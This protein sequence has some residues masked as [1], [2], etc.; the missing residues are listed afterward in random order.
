MQDVAGH[1]FQVIPRRRR[2]L[3][4]NLKV[5]PRQREDRTRLAV[6]ED[7]LAFPKAAT[8]SARRIG[9]QSRVTL[10]TDQA[11]R[12][13]LVFRQAMFEALCLNGDGG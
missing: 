5:V 3:R 11:V 6:A 7:R 8:W 12:A 13:G 9:E 2:M 10:A 4:A 1:S